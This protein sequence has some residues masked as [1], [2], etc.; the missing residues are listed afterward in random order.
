MQTKL[1]PT[2]DQNKWIVKG[3]ENILLLIYIDEY[4]TKMY[5]S[6]TEFITW[7]GLRYEFI[8]IYHLTPVKESLYKYRN[9][10][11]N[12]APFISTWIFPC[13]SM[14]QV[15]PP[16][17]LRRACFD[18]G[19]TTWH[20]FDK[21]SVHVCRCVCLYTLVCICDLRRRAHLFTGVLRLSFLSLDRFVCCQLWHWF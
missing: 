1:N 11:V 15:F 8:G 13:L 9:H 21:I 14:S 20:N 5:F 2:W 16:Y 3:K 7:V 6:L 17:K 18:N 12:L 4:G 10:S 19:D